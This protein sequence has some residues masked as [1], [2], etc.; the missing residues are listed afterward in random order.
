M[1]PLYH[2]IFKT[3]EEPWRKAAGRLGNVTTMS[4][5]PL[6]ESLLFAGRRLAQRPEKRKVLF[7]LTDGKPVV[8]A[9]NEQVTFD[10]ACQAVK[11]LT[12]AG[13]ETV[14]I[15]IL[16]QSVGAI[17]PHHAVINNLQELPKG[18]LGQLCSVLTNRR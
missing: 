2:A 8:G 10:H 14:G 6:G 15:G 11:K 9:W 7:C 5:T 1:V 12:A 16:E 3:F 4:L 18:F 13:V 17:F